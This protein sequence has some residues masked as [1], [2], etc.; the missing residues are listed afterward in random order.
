MSHADLPN[1]NPF[2]GE[3][4]KAWKLKIVSA[5]ATLAFASAAQAQNFDI[6]Y[7][8]TNF[9]ANGQIDVSA[10]LATS[11]FLDVTAGPNQG[12][13]NLVTLTSPLVNGVSN[14]NG[15]LVLPTA[16]QI[17]DDVVTPASNPF[18]DD[19]GLEFANDLSTGFNLWGNAPG[20]YS[21]FDSS[22]AGSVYLVDNGTATIA[23]VPEPSTWALGL[24]AL[25][26]FGLVGLR[27]NRA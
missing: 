11:G 27:R 18:L 17:F 24:I 12:I 15:T 20:S 26:A 3:Q 1:Q 14:G 16:D 6:T 19:N 23:A 21:L 13:Y 8:G 2:P 10:G 25:G 5:L 9:T 22:S 4:M 7:T